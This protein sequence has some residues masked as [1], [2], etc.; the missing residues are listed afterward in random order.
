MPNSALQQTQ[1]SPLYPSHVEPALS[2]AVSVLEVNLDT[3]QKNYLSLC[4]QVNS[5]KVAAVVKAN[6][7]GLGMLPVARALYQVGCRDFFVS[8]LEEGIALRSLAED[9][10][11]FV[12]NGLINHVEK[13]FI[14]YNLV[15]VLNHLSELQRWRDLAFDLNMALPAILHVDTGMA[16][17]GLCAQELMH[18]KNHPDLLSGLDVKYVMSHLA[19]SGNQEHEMNELQLA[20]FE[21]VRA[22]F[23]NIPASLAAS[24]GIFLDPK[25]H[26]DLVRPGGALY[27]GL[28]TPFLQKY[29]VDLAVYLR[30]Q[31]LQVRSLEKD[32]SVGYG[33][34]FVSDKPCRVATLG[35]G[36]A[37][38]YFHSLSNK[39][40]VKIGSYDVPV[41]G[42][43]SMDYVTIDVSDVPESLCQQGAWVD[44]ISQELNLRDV[45][46][47]A[48][49]H[50]Y[51]L[52][53]NIGP[54]IKRLYTGSNL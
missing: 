3:V 11:I 34:S 36:Y 50:A 17:T 27:G 49:T 19:C 29:N 7:Y 24:T 47:V 13:E 44:L 31:I 32:E 52:L 35:I 18:L 5:P 2:H 39:G 43:V 12:F 46:S 38:G 16:R 37:D 22:M 1:S 53:V 21:N 4:A 45:A 15:P 14:R 54:R 40:M 20:R 26:M 23:P 48:G 42:R 30:T 8:H 28:G 51:E 10:Q 25:Y 33:A 6:A 9:I 41:V